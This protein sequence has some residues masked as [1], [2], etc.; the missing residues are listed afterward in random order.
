MDYANISKE[1]R[2]KII[3]MKYRSKEEHI[4]SALSCV[5]V[6][7]VLYHKILNINPKN[8]L[9]ENRDRFVLSKGHAAAVLYAILANRG[10]FEEK[11]L[12]SYCQDGSKIAGHSTRGSLPGVEATA[13]SLGHGLPM[14]T[15]MA[16]AGKI[17]LPAG[18][19]GKKKYKTFVLI[20][21]GECDEGT[22]WEAALFAAHNKLENLTVIIDYNKWQAFGRTSEVLNLEPLAKKWESFGWGVKEINGHDFKEI[23]EV[24]YAVPFE[25]GKPNA[26]ILNTIKGKGISFMED[27]LESHY[28]KLSEEDYKKA[29]AELK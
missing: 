18:R 4:G 19:H 5:D 12:D 10:F 16:L 23:E 6:L 24:L 25:K 1:I 11:L 7:T 2:R 9:D 14:A 20:S 3:E 22:T 17:D 15:G 13:G 26:I 27:K 8:C 29:L 21:D 28:M